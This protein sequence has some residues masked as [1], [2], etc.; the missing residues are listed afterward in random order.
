[1]VLVLPDHRDP[2]MPFHLRGRETRCCR[3]WR[4]G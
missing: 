1:V 3:A 2:V 4:Q